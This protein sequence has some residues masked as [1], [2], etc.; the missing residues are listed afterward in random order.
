MIG[1]V[2]FQFF[3]DVG[4]NLVMTN[5]VAMPLNPP[6]ALVEKEK[7][8]DALLNKTPFDKAPFNINVS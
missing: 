7:L 5:D 2:T 3:V 4:E 1:L 6:I 8:K